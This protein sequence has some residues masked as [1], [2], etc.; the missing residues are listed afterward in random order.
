MPRSRCKGLVQSPMA[1]CAAPPVDAPGRRACRRPGRRRRTPGP[2][3]AARTAPRGPAMRQPAQQPH[4]VVRRL[5]IEARHRLVG[6]HHQRSLRQRPRDRHALRLTAGQSAGALLR[7]MRQTHLAQ[8]VACRRQL[9]AGSPPSAVHQ[10]WCR[11]SVPQATLAS[12]LRRRTRLACCQIIAR[13]SRARRSCSPVE[14]GR[15]GAAQPDLARGRRQRSGDAAQQRGLA[16]AVAAQHDQQ[17][18]R[19]TSRSSRAAPCVPFG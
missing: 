8:M 12:T 2:P 18:A 6:Q 7:K 4:D 15:F 5:R 11:P 1:R 3:D 13:S 16:A 9:P 19:P 10:V 14:A 17:L